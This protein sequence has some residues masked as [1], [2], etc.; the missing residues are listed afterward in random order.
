MEDATMLYATAQPLCIMENGATKTHVFSQTISGQPEYVFDPQT[1]KG[2][3]SRIQVL[4][5]L[6]SI[7]EIETKSGRKLRILTLTREQA[8]QAARIQV[9]GTEYLIISN[10][11]VVA[12]G[13]HLSLISIGEDPVDISIMP[14]LTLRGAGL[15][16]KGS[17]TAFSSYVVTPSPPEVSIP[18]VKNV[19]RNEW[20]IT[21]GTLPSGALMRIK[22]KGDVA[23]LY[24]GSRMIYDN[25][26][27][28]EVFEVSLDRFAE[29]LKTTQLKLT[30]TPMEDSKPVYLD[31]PRP[32]GEPV[33]ESVAL[34]I[35]N[36]IA[37]TV[38][39]A[40]IWT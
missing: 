23:E 15:A 8:L 6:D 18:V 40:N 1:V 13:T 2:D 10:G 26:F 31:V 39:Q 12:H 21:T 4:P 38:D 22:Y 24:L 9:N 33:L 29:E 19:S 28:G 14:P 7:Q 34:V 20:N 25:F 3:E 16:A 27:N 35:E 36:R 32:T 17:S 5:G 30:I 11:A 37:L